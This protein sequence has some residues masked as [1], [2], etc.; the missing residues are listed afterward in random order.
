ML[1]LLIPGVG[2]G[3]GG[4]PVTDGIIVAAQIFTPYVAKGQLFTPH[5]QESE[6]D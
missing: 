4:D 5:V 2:M 1:L 6:I 3:G